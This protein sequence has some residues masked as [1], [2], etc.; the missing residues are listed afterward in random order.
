MRSYEVA[1][2]VANNL[3]SQPENATLVMEFEHDDANDK[4]ELFS[5]TIRYKFCKENLLI[6][7]TTIRICLSN[8]HLKFR[9]FQLQ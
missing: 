7:T 2:V 5:P 3:A 1:G 6:A 4:V 9:V 8:Q